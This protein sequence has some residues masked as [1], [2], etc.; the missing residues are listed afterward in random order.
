LVV[1]LNVTGSAFELTTAFPVPYV[2][3]GMKDPSAFILRVGKQV[4]IR[5]HAAG[6][7]H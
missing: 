1:S 4:D 6:T 5:I 3:W 7:V 2:A